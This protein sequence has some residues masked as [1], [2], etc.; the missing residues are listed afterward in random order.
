MDVAKNF[1]K[2]T[3]FN[4]NYDDADTEI[5]ILTGEGERL[6]LGEYNL[7]WWNAT[8]Y[9]DPAD[10][11]SVEIVRVTD[12]TDDTL[13]ITRGQEGTAAVDHNLPGKTYKM[14]AGLTAKV[15]NVD[16][17]GD[18]H[19]SGVAILISVVDGVIQVRGPAAQSI[20]LSPTNLLIQSLVVNIG[21]IE[22]EGNLTNL[23]VNDAAQLVA[24]SGKIGTNQ[25]AGA[26]SA[27]GTLSAK[28][29]IYDEGGTLLGYI[30]IYDSIT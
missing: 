3:V 23:I 4:G 18:I 29:P 10:D 13:T 26:S 8:D 2:V 20:N 15:V 30:P 28:M 11:P 1:A 24:I 22:G 12:R 7:V 6:P 5:D 16:L 21:D 17:L 14:I 9:P 19:G 27:V 25:S